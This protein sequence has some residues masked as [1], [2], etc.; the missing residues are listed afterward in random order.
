MTETLGVFSLRIMPMSGKRG[1]RLVGALA[2]CGAAAL[3]ATVP[4]AGLEPQPERCTGSQLRLRYSGSEGAAGTIAERLRLV[5]RR[6]IA[7]TLRGYPT[8][9]LQG[10]S[11]DELMIH[12]G[13]LPGTPRTV[14]VSRGHPA[15]FTVRHPSSSPST[16]RPCGIRV[17]AF[18]VVPPR[19]T[20]ALRVSVGS[21]PKPRFCR[22]GARVSPVAK[23]Y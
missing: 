18:A 11:G 21:R 7:C 8:V 6:D 23:S 22:A 16:G 13:R 1:S 9:A 10:R 20:R 19:A 3:L 14:V 4:A 2:V 15:R 17:Y 12:V 5:V